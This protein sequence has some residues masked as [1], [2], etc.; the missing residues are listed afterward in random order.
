MSKASVLRNWFLLDKTSWILCNYLPDSDFLD[1]SL[2]TSLLLF[3][4]D[5]RLDFRKNNAVLLLLRFYETKF[6]MYL[7]S[8]TQSLKI[9]FLLPYIIRNNVHRTLW[10]KE[11]FYT[12]FETIRDRLWFRGMISYLFLI[13]LLAFKVIFLGQLYMKPKKNVYLICYRFI[14]LY[15]FQRLFSNL[16]DFI[17]PLYMIFFLS[18][19]L[20]RSRCL[21]L[22][23]CPCPLSIDPLIDS[24]SLFLLELA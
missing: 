16:K 9:I 11:C 13:G 20:S 6:F 1:L 24:L 10:T 14:H 12:D 21:F 19:S 8:F 5:A 2:D 23:D 7:L 18:L 4:L 15:G 22:S 17:C 3:F